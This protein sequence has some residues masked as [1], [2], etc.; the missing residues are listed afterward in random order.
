MMPVDLPIHAVE[1]A[2][3]AAQ[4]AL[5]HSLD[6]YGFVPNLHGVMAEAPPILKAYKRLGELY[7]ETSMSVLERQVVLLSISAFHACDY[8]MAAHSMLAT[9]EKMPADVL[10]ALRAGAPIPDPKLEALRSFATRMAESRGRV[11][12]AEVD[13]LK[14]HGYTDATVLEVVL[15][16]GYKVL[17][18]YV[19]HLKET[20][21]DAPFTDFAWDR[22]AETAAE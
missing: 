7:A 17:S 22:G 12:P 9:M 19:N 18:N 20:P 5:R 11:T 6:N 14:A 2:P 10:E 21:L 13:A 15:A 16:V 1:T 4:A 8:C 3:D